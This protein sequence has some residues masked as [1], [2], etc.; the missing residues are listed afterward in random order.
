MGGVRT[1]GVVGVTV[2]VLAGSCSSS[3]GEIG[4]P[5]SADLATSTSSTLPPT[6]TVD[7]TALG[8]AATFTTADGDV[9]AYYGWSE[10]PFEVTGQKPVAV[11]IGQCAFRGVADQRGAW[12][13]TRG[14]SELLNPGF[15]ATLQE[16]VLPLWT[17]P[18]AGECSLGW[19]I[20]PVGVDQTPTTL[21]WRNLLDRAEEYT[22]SLGPP[23]LPIELGIGSDP[24]PAGSTV[25]SPDGHGLTV[26]GA[27]RVADAGGLTVPDD[28]FYNAGGAYDP[29]PSGS[30]WWA[31]D[32][33]YCFA[34]DQPGTRVGARRGAI[35]GW[36]VADREG[37]MNAG[38][39]HLSP[40]PIDVDADCE[41]RFDFYAVPVGS[42]LT[43][44]RWTHLDV[45]AIWELD[46]SPG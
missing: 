16:I 38:P 42:A 27:E 31:V 4:V 46:T 20:M 13:L 29:P 33:E 9:I 12:G 34:P 30:V 6:P 44:V 18:E 11:Y 32:H 7:S 37:R 22:W 15:F 23:S 35:D 10:Y 26:F 21:V 24:R 8:E 45:D 25:E 3:S 17:F 36:F 43:H 2:A 5:G 1:L 14:D 19:R 28:A 40:G 41:R 39:D